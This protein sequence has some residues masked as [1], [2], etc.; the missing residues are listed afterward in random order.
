MFLNQSSMICFEV[1]TLQMTSRD[2]LEV[3]SIIILAIQDKPI[4]ISHILSTFVYQQ[5]LENLGK[6]DFIRHKHLTSHVTP[7]YFSIFSSILC[8]EYF[9]MQMQVLFS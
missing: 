7:L 4:G 9:V 6:R 8:L 2:M 5:F 3:Q 1:Y